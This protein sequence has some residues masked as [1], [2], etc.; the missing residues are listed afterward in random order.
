[1]NRSEGK[2]LALFDFDGTLTRYDS[3]F[4]KEDKRISFALELLINPNLLAK[5]IGI[6]TII[7]LAKNMSPL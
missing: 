7:F 2:T 3:L 1:M 5:S 6:E 4:T